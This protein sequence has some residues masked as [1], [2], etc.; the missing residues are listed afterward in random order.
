MW[1]VSVGW[2]VAGR[3]AAE[4]L[5]APSAGLPGSTARGAANLKRITNLMELTVDTTW[6]KS[7]RDSRLSSLIRRIA[8]QNL[9]LQTAAE[10]VVQSVAQ[11][12]VA[13][14][15]GLPHIEGLSS[16]TYNRVSPN[17]DIFALLPGASVEYSL[18]RE[19]LTSSWELDLFG[20][21]RRAVEAADAGALAAVENRR[22]AA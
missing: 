10:R 4:A 15:Q 21:V 22:G 3:L 19:G 18:F 5:P 14:A 20:R 8:A 9:D 17:A 6:W 1:Y 2:S 7:F 11:R 16:N 13:V 12:Q